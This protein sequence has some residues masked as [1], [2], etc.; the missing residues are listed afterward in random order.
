MGDLG[1]LRYKKSAKPNQMNC[2]FCEGKI[3]PFGHGPIGITLRCF[4]CG[5]EWID[6]DN[7]KQIDEFIDNI[8]EDKEEE[9]ETLRRLL[10]SNH[11]CSDID[12]GDEK[13]TCTRCGIDFKNDHIAKIEKALF[14]YRQICG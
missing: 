1:D 3:G 9:N 5:C 7:R 13:M 12:L 10:W 14:D 2:P 8:R 6:S 4:D 11:C